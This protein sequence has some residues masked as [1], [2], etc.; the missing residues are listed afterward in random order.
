MLLLYFLFFC[1]L[2]LYVCVMCDGFHHHRHL[3]QPQATLSKLPKNDKLISWY[4]HVIHTVGRI[5]VG[6]RLFH[7]P[8]FLFL[9]PFTYH[10]IPRTVRGWIWLVLLCACAFPMFIQASPSHALLLSTSGGHA[11]V[12]L[13]TSSRDHDQFLPDNR[14]PRPGM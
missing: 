4:N 1:F 9:F 10:C 11:C 13:P 8:K 7:F 5:I 12:N 6:V 2:H 3:F 14:V